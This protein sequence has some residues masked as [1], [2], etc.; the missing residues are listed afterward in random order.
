MRWTNDDDVVRRSFDALSGEIH[1]SAKG[2]MIEDSRYIRNAASDRLRAAFGDVGAPTAPVLAYGPGDTPVLVAADHAGPAFWL[3]GFGSWGSSDSDGN[4]ASLDRSTG[5]LLIGADGLFGDWRLGVLAGYS[6]SHFDV[7]DRASS[8]KSDNYHLGL[9]GGTQWDDRALR[10]GVAYTWHKPDTSR[11]VIIPGISESLGA[12]Y[13]AGTVQAFGELGY[14]FATG[15][16]RFEPFANLA[17]VSLHTGG[18]G[19]GSGIAALSG[20]SDTT[21]VTFTTL[22]LRAE[23]AL[24]GNATLR[25]MIGWRHAFGDVT[26]ES[27]LAFQG[28]DAFSIAGNPIAHNSALIDAGLDFNLTPY[29][30]LGLSYSGQLAK[31]SRDHGFRANLNVRF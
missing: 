22:G 14:A 12:D 28:S 23:H 17:H 27:T 11:S 4:A 26:P 2:A 6:H 7:K 30:K 3:S 31:S 10:A 1:A 16:A 5:G 21:S 18:F 9:Y 24:A 8:A 20:Q 25:G 15:A 13:H 29:A 19:E